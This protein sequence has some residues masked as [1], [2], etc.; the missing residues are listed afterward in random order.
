MAEDVEKPEPLYIV[1]GQVRWCSFY[2]KVGQFL[3]NI[4]IKLPFVF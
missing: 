2:R 1:E 3:E 4:N